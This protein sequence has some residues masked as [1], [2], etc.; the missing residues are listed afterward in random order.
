MMQDQTFWYFLMESKEVRTASILDPERATDIVARPKSEPANLLHASSHEKYPSS[1]KIQSF[2][3]PEKMEEEEIKMLQPTTMDASLKDPRCV[4]WI[5]HLILGFD[6]I[7]VK[8]C[9]LRVH[10]LSARLKIPTL[11]RAH[12]LGKSGICA[13]AC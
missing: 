2:L 11:N 1:S 5:N 13:A 6:C 3:F 8:L 7:K 9:D 10:S 4:L 12:F